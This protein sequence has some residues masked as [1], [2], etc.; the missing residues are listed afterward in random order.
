VQAWLA[1]H[2]PQLPLPSQTMLVPQLVPPIL[3]PPSAQVWAPVA[4]DV[5]PFLQMLGLVVQAVPAVQATQLPVPLQTMLVP[6]LVPAIL[7]PPSTHSWV[8][9]EH[10]VVPFLQALVGFVVHETP[11]V[12]AT[13]VPAPLQ[14]MFVPQLTPGDLL[15]P[16]TQVWA[17]V[18]QDVVPF[19]QTLGLVLHDV[20]TVQATQVPEPLHTMF[21]PQP[22]PGDLLVSSTQVEA[23]VAQD[24]AP[25]LHTFGLV[26]HETPAA[27]AIQ[28][29]EPLHTMLAPQL[30]PPALGVP[31][32]HVCAPLMHDAM[33]LWQGPGLPEQL[34][35]SLHVP[36]NPLPSQTW[37]MPHGVPPVTLPVP[38]MHV[39][40]PVVHDVTPPLHVDGLPPHAVP[41][42]HMTQVREPLHTM[43]LPHAVPG[44]LAVPSMQVCTPVAHELTPL[45]HAAPGLV[46]HARP[47]VHS[48]HWPLALHT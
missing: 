33:P 42:M 21:V 37:F 20:P 13:Q 35:P 32:A 2:E 25:F 11:A 5:A 6:Q 9:V 24:V 8:P 4:Q 46:V 16:L 41:A 23:P 1:V 17:P 48:A 31:L 38:S 3:L 36:Q 43:L 34:C 10:E 39:G 44:A 27:Q 22:R 40:A 47:A 28:P 14:T 18:E 12:Q 7:S 19:M 45:T 29:P 15:L 26:V 30:V